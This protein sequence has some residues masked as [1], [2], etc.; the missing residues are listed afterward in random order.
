MITNKYDQIRINE[1]EIKGETEYGMNEEEFL[2]YEFIYRIYLT[3][4][5][6]KLNIKEIKD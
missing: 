4:V 2:E 6:K 3:Q 5:I 1:L